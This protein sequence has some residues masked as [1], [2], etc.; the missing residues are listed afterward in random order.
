ME[1]RVQ[2][3]I[4]RYVGNTPLDRIRL[5]D[6]E[7]R[8][9]EIYAKLEFLNPGGSIK[10]RPMLRMV[11]E[12]IKAGELS[13][14][15][16]LLDS[17]SGN[18]GIAYSMIGSVLGQSVELVVPGTTSAEIRK[19]IQAFGGKTIVSDAAAGYVGAIEK[20]HELYE[21]NKERYFMADQYANRWNPVAHYDTT[22]LEILAQTEGRVTHFVAGVGTGG[23]LMGVARRLKEHNPAIKVYA[24]HPEQDIPGIEGLGPWR[25]N[26]HIPEIFDESLLDEHLFVSSAKAKEMCRVLARHGYFVGRSSG[27]NLLGALEVGKMVAEGVIVTAFPDTASRY[28]SNELFAWATAGGVSA[29]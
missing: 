28:Y 8:G 5:G 27:A 3:S 14:G 10:D 6:E 2:R 7:E 13:E 29:G 4:L 18:A 1:E 22:G 20:V 9:L 15:R 11:V 25:E 16:V 21:A 17:T 12:A 19:T 26:P 23:T 24:L